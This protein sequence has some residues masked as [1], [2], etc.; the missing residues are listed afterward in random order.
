MRGSI[1][2]PLPASS[3][4]AP[5]PLRAAANL[6]RDFIV[7]RSGPLDHPESAANKRIEPSRTIS[8]LRSTNA[9]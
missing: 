3:L 8:N 9:V 5:F 1:H 7:M 4:F 6:D 2:A